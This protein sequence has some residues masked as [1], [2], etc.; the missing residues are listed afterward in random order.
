MSKKSVSFFFFHNKLLKIL[1]NISLIN[2]QKKN[3]I[4][5][6]VNTNYFINYQKNLLVFSF[7]IINFF[8]MIFFVE[9]E[10]FHENSSLII[11]A[12]LK[13]AVNIFQIL[14]NSNWIMV[15]IQTILQTADMIWW[16]IIGKWK[17]SLISLE[18]GIKNSGK[19]FQK[20]QTSLNDFPFQSKTYSISLFFLNLN[21][22]FQ[23]QN[24]NGKFK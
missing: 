13:K 11:L 15:E 16:V 14:K 18:L 5:A 24:P 19:P 10:I 7:S 12:Q 2:Y 20:L 9:R 4:I 8:F 21:R 22:Q 6:F 3:L 1:H 23:I 17:F